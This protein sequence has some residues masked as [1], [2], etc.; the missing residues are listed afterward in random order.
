MKT[1]F[2][3]LI[4]IFFAAPAFSQ[5]I[6]VSFDGKRD[7][8]VVVDGSTY[9]SDAYMN[10]D[11]VL[12]NLTGE[13]N[14]SI[15][16]VNKKGKARQVY[17]SNLTLSPGEEVHLTINNNSIERSETSSNLAYNPGTPMSEATY[18]D[19]YSRVNNQWGQAAKM[20][21]A[22]DV[23]NTSS[24]RFSSY[25]V[26]RIIRLINSEADRLAL[27]KLAYDKVTDPANYYQVSNLLNSQ[28]GRNE[29]DNYIRNYDYD[30]PYNG[31]K[32]PMN[33]SNFNQLYRDISNEWSTSA[34]MSA[35]TNAFTVSTNYFTVAQAKQLISLINDENSRLQLAKLSVDN[36]VDQENLNQLFDLFY[37]QSSKDELDSYIR[38]SGYSGTDYNSHQAMSETS[39]NSIY[40]DI[41]GQWWPGSKMSSLVETF[42]T[43]T[44]YFSTEQAKQLIGLVSAESNRV[45]LA[46]LSFDNIADPQN[47]R[48]I[49]DLLSSQSSRDEVDEYIRVKY[50][51]Q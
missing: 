15:Y 14:V 8:Q 10:N 3:V 21:T 43:P 40:N 17:T 47:F 45:E 9:R 4:S 42:N 11:L 34:R 6:R 31:Y 5:S 36:I 16:R 44:N 24:Y 2:S 13:H 49:Y 1:I 39:F 23:F 46:K 50:N 29:L 18:N 22:R 12:S 30:D 26:S 20:A 25:Q 7:F 51:Y 41:R 32:V 37:Y 35:A 38:N 33:S 19:V 48:Q 27:A 28:A